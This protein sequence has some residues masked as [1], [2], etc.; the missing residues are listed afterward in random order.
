MCCVCG[1]YVLL[2]CGVLF[3]Y[4]FV[5]LWCAV[6]VR[7]VFVWQLCQIGGNQQTRNK[8]QETSLVKP[9]VLEQ[10]F[11]FFFFFPNQLLVLLAGVN[12]LVHNQASSKAKANT[13]KRGRR[14]GE[15]LHTPAFVL[16][17]LA[18]RI[19][20]SR[21]A[22]Q[23]ESGVKDEWRKACI[24]FLWEGNESAPNTRTKKKKEP[25]PTATTAKQTHAHTHTHTHTHTNTRTQ[26]KGNRPAPT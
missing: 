23:G 14:V 21:E 19:I 15:G 25:P 8:T 6:C 16:D 13:K 12:V 22:K 10:P 24:L 11:S 5:V 1:V 7:V 26:R 20:R 18:G 2:L 4:V 3:V 9:L 17:C